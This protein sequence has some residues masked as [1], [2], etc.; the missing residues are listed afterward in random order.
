MIG[1]VWDIN[2]AQNDILLFNVD[3]DRYFDIIQAKRTHKVQIVYMLC[4]FYCLNH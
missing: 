1:I 2:F 3:N 4:P